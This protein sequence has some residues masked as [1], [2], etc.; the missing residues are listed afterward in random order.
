MLKPKLEIDS[1]FFIGH[2]NL[3]PVILQSEAKHTPS[4]TLAQF[5]NKCYEVVQTKVSWIHA[6]KNCLS[7]K[8]QLVDIRS[9]EEQDFLFHYLESIK[10]HTIWLGLHDRNAEEKF[11]WTSGKY[12]LITTSVSRQFVLMLAK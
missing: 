12:H 6:E 8:G 1:S 10:S 2:T 3:C 11:E 5:R 9:Q 7:K 4:I